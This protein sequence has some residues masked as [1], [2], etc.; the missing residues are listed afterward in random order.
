M[1]KLK[2]GIIGGGSIARHCH[3]P[4]YAADPD[5]ILRQLP[6]RRPRRCR[7]SGK[8]GRSNTNMPIT[9]KCSNTNNWIWS[10]FA[11]RINFT[12]VPQLQRW[13]PVPT[14]SWKSRSPST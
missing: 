1:K 12:P 14:S 3:L 2:I 9:G 7:R 4:G 13:N 6:T 10:P 11:H 8:S 5:C